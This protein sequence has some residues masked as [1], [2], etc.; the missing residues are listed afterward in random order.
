M[1]NLSTKYPERVK[2]MV[3]KFKSIPFMK[4]KTTKNVKNED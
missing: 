4:N 1:I 2:E 3:A